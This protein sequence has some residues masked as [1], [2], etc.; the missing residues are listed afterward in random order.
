LQIKQVKKVFE[1]Y[2]LKA[3]ELYGFN[4]NI[5]FKIDLK[6]YSTIGQCIWRDKKN[7]TIR[8]HLLLLEKYGDS[9]LHDVLPHEL[10]HAVVY[11]LYKNRVKAHGKEWKRI[12]K[13][14]T[15]VDSKV[16]YEVLQKIRESKRYRYGCKCK[17]KVH[18]I[19]TILHN[20]IEKKSAT[21][22]CKVC[23]DTICLI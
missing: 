8:L 6:G 2:F 18:F 21:Y 1:P 19:S 3:K 20:K 5:D 23:K 4:S 13:S 16:K 10:A 17:D 7:F 15:L 22:L 12:L 9:Y 11:C 14:F